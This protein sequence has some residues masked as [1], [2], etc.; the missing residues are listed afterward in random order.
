MLRLC[1]LFPELWCLNAEFL[2]LLQAS[3]PSYRAIDAQIGPK[4]FQHGAVGARHQ[5]VTGCH[6]RVSQLVAHHDTMVP[7]YSGTMVPWY[8]G[9]LNKNMFQDQNDKV[10]DP[11]FILDGPFYSI[12][13]LLQDEETE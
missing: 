9:K 6:D 12:K 5:D 3:D 2:C 8:H 4:I 11:G 1:N 13:G 7:W 10:Q